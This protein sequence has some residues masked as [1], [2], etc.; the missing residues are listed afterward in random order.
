MK[1]NKLIILTLITT[2]ALCWEWPWSSSGGIKHDQGIEL[3]KGD[4]SILYDESN[5][6]WKGQKAIGDSHTGNIKIKTGN[7]IIDKNGQ[8]KGSLII[9]MTTINNTDQEGEWKDKLEGHLKSDDFFN[10][11][12]FKVSKLNFQSV[13]RNGNLLRFDGDLT[14][15]NISHPISFAANISESEGKII[16][17]SSLVFDRSIYDVKYGSGTF[18][19]DL[20]DYLILDD[21]NLEVILAIER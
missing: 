1:I 16:A 6:I 8:V 12:K 15:K 3:P 10:V 21:I 20:G 9:D 14:I 11:D 5:L 7:I 19:E 13:K 4:H 18:F 17:Q 2:F